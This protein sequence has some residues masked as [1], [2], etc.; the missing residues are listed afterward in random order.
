VAFTT[1][2]G[3]ARAGVDYEARAG[4]L[5]FGP[6]VFA[7]NFTVT[8]LPNTR[9][10]GD[11]SFTVALSGPTGGAT[12]GTTSTASVLIKD[13][14]VGGVVQFTATAYSVSECAAAPCQAVLTVSRTGGGASGVTVDF[15]TADGTATALNDYVAT[16]GQLT[17]ASSQLSATIRIPLQIE[18][19]A[20]PLKTFSVILSNVRGGAI[21]G[22]RPSA[23]VR[24]TDTR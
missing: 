24:I 8:V 3:T 20:Q 5:T 4:V 14:D 19:G 22:T 17:F 10:D 23:E 12:L 2:D 7:V 21:L 18:P 11:R 16:T 13:N 15:A 1:V 6:G 9:D